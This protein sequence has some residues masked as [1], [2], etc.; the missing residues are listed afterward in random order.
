MCVICMAKALPEWERFEAEQRA[1]SERETS[2]ARPEEWSRM[3]DG[4]S[5]ER[6]PCPAA[7][8]TIRT[9]A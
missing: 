4:S 8:R 9:S 6:H 2:T 1:L 7:G 5:G 3:D